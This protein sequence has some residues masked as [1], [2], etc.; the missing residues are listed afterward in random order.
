MKHVFMITYSIIYV[1]KYK[2]YN[3]AYLHRHMLGE[4]GYGIIII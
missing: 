4:R 2:M 1:L 3:M